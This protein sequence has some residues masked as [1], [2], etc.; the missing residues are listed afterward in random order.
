MRRQLI[1]VLLCMFFCSV[2][3]AN[4]AW[5]LEENFESLTD[6]Y[7]LDVA[8]EEG[9]TPVIAGSGAL[10]DSAAV[11]R[12]Q[13]GEAQ[14][15]SASYT[16]TGDT[17]YLRKTL[18]TGTTD[19]VYFREYIW[20]AAGHG[21]DATNEYLTVLNLRSATSIALLNIYIEFD[22]SAVRLAI[23]PQ[24]F[25]SV[26]GTYDYLDSANKTMTAALSTGQWYQVRGSMRFSEGDYGKVYCEVID[27]VT[28]NVIMD[29]VYTCG[30]GQG[31]NFKQY[32]TG[33]IA[34]NS[35]QA[36]TVY[37]D[38]AAAATGAMPYYQ[39]FKETLLPNAEGSNTWTRSAGTSTYPLLND[40]NDSTYISTTADSLFQ[41][42]ALSNPAAVTHT[43]IGVR[44]WHRATGLA[45]SD[46]RF[47][48]GCSITGDTGSLKVVAAAEYQNS[49]YNYQAKTYVD[50]EDD[51]F[52]WTDLNN[53][54]MTI[55]T[56]TGEDSH[57]GLL[58]EAWA[59]IFS[60]DSDEYPLFN[61]IVFGDSTT[62]HVRATVRL[63]DRGAQHV[64]L[65]Y[66]TVEA[67]VRA[68]TGDTLETAGYAVSAA[69]DYTKKFLIEGLAE[70]TRYYFD[71]IID[72][73]STASLSE[74]SGY[75]ADPLFG[76]TL[77]S[78]KTA[79]AANAGNSF[80]FALIGDDQVALING[81]NWERSLASFDPDFI[82]HV[83]DIQTIH[84]DV[85]AT[86]RSLFKNVFDPS[87][88]FAE[89]AGQVLSSRPFYYIWSDHDLAIND[90]D[91]Y[92]RFEVQNMQNYRALDAVLDYL[93]LPTLAN[94]GD[95][96]GT[97]TG[98]DTDTLINS[99]VDFTTLGIYPGQVVWDI[100]DSGSCVVQSVT[101]N[102]V[103]C[104]AALSAGSF[105][106]TDAYVIKS[107]GLWYKF[108][109]GDADFF[110]I[111]TRYKRDPNST[112][113]G[114]MLDGMA[115]GSGTGADV[116]DGVAAGHEQRDWLIAQVNASTAQWKFIVDQIPIKSDEAESGD[117]WADYDPNDT[118]STY[119]K[120]QITADGVV[121]LAGDRHS[122]A[123]DD[124]ETTAD[125]PWPT[126]MP[127]PMYVGAF[128]DLS[129][130]YR[131]FG[132]PDVV[133]GL[134]EN[135][136]GRTSFAIVDVYPHYLAISIYDSD[137]VLLSSKLTGKLGIFRGS[138]DEQ[139]RI[140]FS[141][142][143]TAGG[144]GTRQFPFNAWTDFPFTGYNLRTGAEIRFS[145]SLGNL[146]ISGLTDDPTTVDV[147]PWQRSPMMPPSMIMFSHPAGWYDVTVTR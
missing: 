138:V 116:G 71:V 95:T 124:G 143:A 88:S 141:A 104:T 28:G 134:D 97:A 72:G 8:N 46:C 101:T 130:D 35:A 133:F 39:I 1:A 77:P 52:T 117:K 17:A 6:T 37:I 34:S 114:D 31:I 22:N 13:Y 121:W 123:M 91:K 90:G 81:Q 58:T 15:L 99:G 36:S 140:Y 80:R 96:Y 62:D 146:D 119:L 111:D 23:I 69:D 45:Q 87:G 112:A 129:G 86:F 20:L 147:K 142:S 41:S 55:A 65:R 30:S 12:P 33:I 7:G 42:V 136:T 4:A 38:R 93:P 128:H 56:G 16:T 115:H 9:W 70:Y 122:S 132:M 83:G 75:R 120:V 126:I 79:V 49:L 27:E 103:E 51:A 137:G 50:G 64:A 76:S 135:T 82:L 131:W 47:T 84:S 85:D 68:N 26:T 2:S 67:D 53:L 113:D 105:D 18:G 73:N 94:D 144:K 139:D 107:G 43:P 5:L 59:E 145:G 125:D 48:R 32:Q 40:G 57:G 10:S 109:W 98:G 106:A 19:D 78:T 61:F 108:S 3:A 89:F 102:N 110:V 74:T 127:G 54:V 29:V 118:Q 100:T 60:G 63:Q 66:G 14:V 92:G 24:V 44:L 25:G 21:L 11:A